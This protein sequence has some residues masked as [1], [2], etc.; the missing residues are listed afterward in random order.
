M[1]KLALFFFPILLHLFFYS[2][3]LA[4][5]K[6]EKS[7]EEKISFE[8][9]KTEENDSSARKFLLSVNKKPDEEIEVETIES[10]DILVFSK[11]KDGLKDV[12]VK[13][14]RPSFTIENAVTL[15]EVTK[16][17][18]WEDEKLNE[19]FGVPIPENANEKFSKISISTFLEYTSADKDTRFFTSLLG[20]TVEEKTFS[21]TI[22]EEVSFGLKYRIVRMYRGQLQI[23]TSGQAL[24]AKNYEGKN[25]NNE[26]IFANKTNTALFQSIEIKPEIDLESLQNIFFKIDVGLKLLDEKIGFVNFYFEKPLNEKVSFIAETELSTIVKN[27]KKNNTQKFGSSENFKRYGG[28]LFKIGLTLEIQKGEFFSLLFGHERSNR[29]SFKQEQLFL[30]YTIKF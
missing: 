7:D 15:N 27:N 13:K 17:P 12:R 10:G 1:K 16:I 21:Y 22:L 8:D 23:F 26:L 4:K 11:G 3:V 25:E 9:Y 24:F 2:T 14:G 5:T 28:Y 6:K 19:E 30:K 20:S 18:T 29:Y